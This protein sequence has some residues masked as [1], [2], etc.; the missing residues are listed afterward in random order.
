MRRPALLLTTVA[1]VLSGLGA[2]VGSAAAQ[3]AASDSAGYA[4]VVYDDTVPAGYDPASDGT[5]STLAENGGGVSTRSVPDVGASAVPGQ[6]EG[7]DVSSYQPGVNWAA[8]AANGGRF[9]YVKATESSGASAYRNPEY[10]AQYTGSYNAGLIRGAYHFALPNR[11]SGAVQAQFF[12]ANGGGWSADA[13]TLPPML[14][15]EYNP[16]GA[17]CYGLTASQMVGWIRDFSDTVNRLTGRY[18]TIYSTAD[19]W[20]TCT[21]RNATFGATNP[22]FVANYVSSPYG[23]EPI[24]PA[25]WAFQT[26][27]QWSDRGKFPGDQNVFNGSYEQLVTFARGGAGGGTTP[28]PTTTPV[29]SS[30]ALT[31][32][33]NAGVGVPAVLL[34]A[35]VAPGSATGSVAFTAGGAGIAGCAAVPVRGG[36]ATCVTSFGSPG[37]V[38]LGAAYGGDG[39]T[40]ASR[41][42]TPVAVTAT[43]DLIQVITGYLIQ[44]A[45]AFGLV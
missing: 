20:N 9:A 19:W 30:V 3:P 38:T 5:G 16:Y 44:L 29:G 7:L 6:P 17:T 27:W 13:R 18:P 12:V 34:T 39:A 25:G 4:D 2:G 45:R 24:L 35:V 11:S 8:V 41:T 15:I 28:P 36:V 23:R 43:P 26:I 37:T 42:T 21:G 40:A 1:L 33:G 10:D 32:S 22:L 14:D 31:T